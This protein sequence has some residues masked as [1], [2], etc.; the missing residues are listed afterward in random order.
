MIYNESRRKYY[1]KEDI[2]ADNIKKVQELFVKSGS[3][4]YA[5]DKMNK[6]YDEAEDILK[7]IKWIKEDKKE[8]LEGFVE[9]LR[10]R[11]K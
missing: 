6:M 3:Y 9:Y 7:Q 8:L 10:K 1:G 11:N 4:K 5:Y 2:S